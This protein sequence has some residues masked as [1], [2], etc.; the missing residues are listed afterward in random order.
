MN[1]LRRLVDFGGHHA[2]RRPFAVPAAVQHVHDCQN[3]PIPILVCV[4]P[5]RCPTD[6]DGS[7]PEGEHADWRTPLVQTD[8]ETTLKLVPCPPVFEGPVRQRREA[9]VVIAEL[10]R[11][12]GW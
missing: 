8:V 1:G 11:E 3:A 2:N 9:F 10:A 6:R 5:W 12:A 4:V 7:R